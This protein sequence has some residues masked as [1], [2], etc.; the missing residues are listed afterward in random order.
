M[1]IFAAKLKV[2]V[3]KHDK[4]WKRLKLNCPTMRFGN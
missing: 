4:T 2:F 3:K 1:R